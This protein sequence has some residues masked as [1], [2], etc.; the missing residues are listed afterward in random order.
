MPYDDGSADIVLSIEA[1]S[2]HLDVPASIDEARR[3]L[4]PAGALII[5]DPTT[6]PIRCYGARP[7]RSGKPSRRARREEG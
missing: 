2:H 7:T 5:A 4:R 6:R 1:I 3:V